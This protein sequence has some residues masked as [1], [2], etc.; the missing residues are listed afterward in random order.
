MNQPPAFQWYAKDHLA[1]TRILLMT[2]AEEGAYVRLLSH[3][4][5]DPFCTLPDDDQQLAI[6]SR[7]GEGWF[8]G[9]SEKIRA[10]FEKDPRRPGRIFSPKLR[11]ERKKQASWR[12]KSREGGI[13][14]GKSR[15]NKLKGGSSTEGTKNELSGNSSVFS[16]QSSVKDLK[17]TEPSVQE[18]V[19]GL[20]KFFFDQCK[21]IKGFEPQINAVD[22]KLLKSLLKKYPEKVLEGLILWFLKS[23]ESDRLSPSL[24]VCCSSYMVNKWRLTTS[25]KTGIGKSIDAAGRELRPLL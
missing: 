14:S 5:G 20:M 12:A 11:A 25:G 13:K 17:P 1:D 15:R 10:C 2:P 16:L 19:S 23:P 21:L 3:C 4:W 18:G 22:G 8:S 7:L 6:L 9:S 24:S